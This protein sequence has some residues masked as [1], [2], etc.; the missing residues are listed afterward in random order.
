MRRAAIVSCIFVLFLCAGCASTRIST[1]RMFMYP[2]TYTIEDRETGVSV[3]Y[4]NG[5]CCCV[6]EEVLHHVQKGI[7]AGTVDREAFF[8][9]PE[10]RAGILKLFCLE[11]GG[12]P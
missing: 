10:Y 4:Y 2:T 9:D 12:T 3:G 1:H 11:L 7:E 6:A 5:N 8:S